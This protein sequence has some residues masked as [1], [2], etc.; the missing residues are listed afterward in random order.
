MRGRPPPKPRVGTTSY[1]RT[2][3]CPLPMRFRHTHGH[4][5]RFGTCRNNSRGLSRPLTPIAGHASMYVQLDSLAR[6]RA[7]T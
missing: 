2:S 4:T 5:A 7:G 1:S 6:Y 3:R